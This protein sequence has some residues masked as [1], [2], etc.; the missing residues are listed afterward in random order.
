METFGIH[1]GRLWFNIWLD[2]CV[3]V[4]VLAGYEPPEALLERDLGCDA[5]YEMM[6][7]ST[8]LARPESVGCELVPVL[9]MSKPPPSP[10]VAVES[11]PPRPDVGDESPIPLPPRPVDVLVSLLSPIPGAVP[12]IV[13]PPK[14]DERVFVEVSGSEP[15]MPE[16]GLEPGSELEPESP[17][18]SEMDPGANTPLEPEGA[19]DPGPRPESV[20][21]PPLKPL[22]V[23]PC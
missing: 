12:V 4:S 16:P 1:P 5:S 18:P 8:A 19:V 15:L 23:A 13:G 10:V 20:V 6:K 3:D 11:S 21:V 14:L 22:L 17:K 7:L 2:T 9:V